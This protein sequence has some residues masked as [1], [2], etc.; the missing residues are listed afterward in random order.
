[1]NVFPPLAPSGSV[2]GAGDEG[3]AEWSKA[4]EGP[5]AAVQPAAH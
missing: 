4:Q 3:F 5:G 1:M 2:L